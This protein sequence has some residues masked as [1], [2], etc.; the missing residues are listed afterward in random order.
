MA[1]E[2]R[3]WAELCGAPSGACRKLCQL[4]EVP[5]TAQGWHRVR[6]LPRVHRALEGARMGAEGLGRCTHRCKA[7]G[8]HQL[9]PTPHRS[10]SASK[11][12]TRHS[13]TH[14]PAT[15]RVHGDGLATGMPPSPVLSPIWSPTPSGAH[16]YPVPI[17]DG[18]RRRWPQGYM[19][20]AGSKML[21][22]SKVCMYGTSPT[23][24]L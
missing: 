1:I 22:P 11:P 8:I 21:A 6:Q 18:S 13:L 23:G 4:Q 10:P 19:E 20:G 16:S 15:A 17:W 12:H 7:V 5:A 2:G 14:L 3:H 9:Y 24:A